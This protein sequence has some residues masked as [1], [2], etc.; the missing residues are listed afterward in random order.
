MGPVLTPG[1]KG[2]EKAPPA[3]NGLCIPDY[4]EARAA[5]NARFDRRPA[6][7]VQAMGVADVQEALRFA[8]ANDLVIAVRGGGHTASGSSTIDG[9]MLIDLRLMRG[10]HVD[11]ENR[12]AVAAGGTLLAELDRE[13]QAHGLATTT[14]T[15]S[16]T[17]I[18]GLT[19]F[20]GVGR[21]MRK[22]GLT[23]DSM[24][25]IDIV[26]ADSEWLHVDA[27]HHPDL[28]W[29]L[30]G[31]GGTFGVVTHFTYALHPVGPI[32]Y[33][34][35]LGWP[36]EQSKD[37]YLAVREH[38]ADAPEDLWVQIIFCT[39][40]VADFI[41]PE[42][43]GTPCLMMTVT[44]VGDDLDEG[45]RMIAPFR[46][47]VAPTLDVVGPF[48]YAFLQAA[49]DPLAPHGKLNCAAMPGFLDDLTEEIFDVGLAQAENFPGEYAIVEF[50]QMGGAV[51][52]VPADATAVPAAFRDARFSYVLG[53]NTLDEA[54]IDAC[55]QWVF[56]ADAALEPYRRPGRYVNFM[57][58]DDEDAMREALG[59]E[60]YAR[61]TEIKA[62]YDPDGVFSYNPN[63]RAAAVS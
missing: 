16:H 59:E 33:G 30:R 34:G 45:E 39:A 23:V 26:T 31:G 42:L 3:W 38:L 14:G 20:G 58:E 35:Y 4:D 52:R 8:R 28:F 61:L 21:L 40:P 2:Y 29:A 9:G 6:V 1:D 48:P 54:E 17:G 25:A 5:W 46:E 43:Q 63:H 55:R 27:D 22:Y 36:L 13:C 50:A 19:L 41:P 62:E 44:W 15:V 57:S 18:G 11:A 60:T 24:L 37:V 12:V 51:L 47:K 32:V 56:D 53:S 10:V 7:I 49:S